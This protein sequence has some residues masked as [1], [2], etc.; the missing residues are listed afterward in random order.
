MDYWK[1]SNN[2]A[3]F[4]DKVNFNIERVGCLE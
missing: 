2:E 4:F 1:G 3:L